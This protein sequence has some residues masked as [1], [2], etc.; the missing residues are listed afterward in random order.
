MSEQDRLNIL[1]VDDQPAKLLSYEVILQDLGERLLKAHSG[2]EA[3]ETLL[4]NEIAVILVDVC[5]PQLDG[6]ELAA[7]IRDHPRCKKIAI[8]FI[9]AIHL[10]DVDRLRG[11]EM[12]AVDYV[13]V[14]VVPEV[15]RAKVRVFAELYRKTRQ[16][17]NLNAELEKRVADR[18]AELESYASRLRESERRRSLALAAGQMGSWDWDLLTGDCMWDGG[19]YR[20][21]G[22]EPNSFAIT[23][24]VMRELLEPSEFDRL[25][26]AWQSMLEQPRVQDFEFRINRPDGHE[27]WCLGTAAASVD[28][29]GRVTRISGVTVDITERKKAEERQV[30]LA[31]EVD[32]R[33]RNVLAVVQSILRLTK[34]SSPEAYVKTVEGR[35]RALSR[36]HILLSESRWEGADLRRLVDEE[37][38]PY[39]TGGAARISAS[40]IDVTLMPRAAQTVAMVLHELA[41]N[42]AKYGALSNPASGRITIDWSM[43]DGN[44]TINW[45]E[46]GGPT[47]TAP[48][49]EGYGMKLIEASLNQIG[50]KAIFDWSSDGLS[51]TLKISPEQSLAR[52]THDEPSCEKTTSAISNIVQ[53]KNVLVIEDE[54]LVAMMMT[55]AL[56]ELGFHVVG[57]CGKVAEGIAALD[58]YEVHAAVLDVNLGDEQVYPVAELLQA[59]GIPFAFVTGYGVESV[60]SRFRHVPILQKPIDRRA[61]EHIFFV[62]PSAEGRATADAQPQYDKTRT[63]CV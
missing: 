4:K 13:P 52:R 20:I 31:R 17:E 26:A 43:H 9:S 44:L 62:K 41:T 45:A 14:P 38:A 54:A 56:T 42:A 40:G 48:S 5:M 35:I 27:R 1:L 10:T 29:D 2:A 51:C 49:S 47:A 60:D 58:K 16:L 39:L 59:R 55:D 63:A 36:A 11:Y 46:S 61:L 22:A 28:G 3:L 18:T 12:G 15:L 8:I 57:P 33:A 32:H 21:F 6:F 30:F 24:E 7:M 19:Q 23:A 50:G 53:G 25:H 37:L 34:A